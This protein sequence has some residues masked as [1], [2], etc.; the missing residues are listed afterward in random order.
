[1]N[2]YNYLARIN[3]IKDEDTLY[4]YLSYMK[5]RVSIIDFEKIA[6]A[7]DI[8]QAELLEAEERWISLEKTTKKCRY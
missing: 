8:R 6:R 1:M 4:R 2:D 7:A 3:N 5:A